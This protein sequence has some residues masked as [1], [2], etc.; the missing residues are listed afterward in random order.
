[1]PRSQLHGSSNQLPGRID[2]A[3]GSQARCVLSACQQLT[4]LR[5]T[6]GNSCL[7]RWLSLVG[8][9]R[10][11]WISSHCFHMDGLVRAEREAW[12]RPPT[13][14]WPA[15]AHPD[16][17]HLSVSLSLTFTINCCCLVAKIIATPHTYW[18]YY[19]PVNAIYK[20]KMTTFVQ[21]QLD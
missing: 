18:L 17:Q 1:M 14:A 16:R 19:E 2:W 7:A 20:I 5:W 11:L 4:T 13:R 3:I 9:A 8:V 10:V 21:I 6:A 12:P 15:G